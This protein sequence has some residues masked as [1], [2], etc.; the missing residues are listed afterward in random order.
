MSFSFKPKS[1]S[2]ADTMLGRMLGLL[3]DA[4]IKHRKF[5]LWP[6][7][8]L[9]GLCVF[10]TVHKLEFD[11]DRDNLVGS[12][13]KY[14]QLYLQ[15]KHEFP[16]Q[17]DM[18]VVVES[19]NTEKNRQFVERLGKKLD[20]ETGLF[21]NVFYKGDMKMLGRKALLFVPDS[22]LK[23]MNDALTNFLPFIKEFTRA[24]NL[25]SLFQ[26]VNTQIYHAKREANAD[27]DALLGAIPMLTRIVSQAGACLDRPGTPPSPGVTALFG[28][29][30]EAEQKIY[31][32]FTNGTSHIYLVTAQAA[33]DEKSGEAVDRMRKLVAETAEEVPGINI[34]VTGESVLEHDEMEQSQKDSTLASIVSL[35]ICALIFIYGYQETGRPLK[36]TLCLLVGLGYTMAFTTLVIGHLNILTI[37]FAPI[38]IGLAIDFGVHL[39]TRYE[40]ELRLGKSEEDAMRKAIVFTGQGILT[41]A[42]TT[43]VAFLA[44]GLTNFKGIQEMGIICGGGMIICFIPM[45]TLLPVLLFKGRQNVI[46]HSPGAV[47]E[48][49]R[50][51]AKIEGIWLD[52]PISTLIIT[53]ALTILAVT[54]FHRV[55]FD[56]NLLNMQSAGLSAVVFEKK[57]LDTKQQVLYGA[58][59]ADSAEQAV[60]LEAK[61]KLLPSVIDTVSMAPYLVADVSD[62]LKIIGQIKDEISSVNFLPTDT[63]PANL[64]DLSRTLYSTQGY[65]GAAADEVQKEAA[66]HPAPVENVQKPQTVP[67]EGAN[68]IAATDTNLAPQL[69]ALRDA[70]NQFRKKMLNMDQN[71][72][73][74][75]IAAFQQALLDDVRDTFQSLKE[76]D[77]S[78]RLKVEDLP[79]SLKN[80]FVG[81]H[82]KLMIQVS[83]RYDIW[84]HENQKQFVQQVRSVCPN[85]TGT[86]V[87]LLEYT[88]L[89]KN[90]YIEAA[91]YA[92]AVIVLMVL[93][94]FRSI[95]YLVLALLPVAIGAV[96]M[97]GLMGAFGIPFNPANIMTL[98][99]VIGIGITN[100]IHI[101]NRYAE[102]HNA[103]I[104]SKSTGKAVFVSGL[105]TF[106]GFA[107][108]IL[109]KHQGIRSLGE[110][111]A[112]GVALCMIAALTFLPAILK[113]WDSKKQP[114][115]GNAQ[116]SPGREEPRQKPQ[117]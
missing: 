79:S 28:A 29:G 116:S 94:H 41:G 9:F 23:D 72:A 19:E 103:S 90:S 82:G 31:I 71:V 89:L 14:H 76:Q 67:A 3:A 45:M 114:G 80:R 32:T 84:D 55:Y 37:T 111:M 46:D 61:L 70:I 47:R 18:V 115:G 38:L 26:L 64:E 50:L 104:L 57:L 59:V 39:I 34:G 5:F 102:E 106:S 48:D 62:K 110:V 117:G 87:Q 85:V 1:D 100:G 105:T 33:S 25:V 78:S 69:L 20:A 30:D 35:V 10:Y 16:A 113:L 66:S 99:L 13:K 12:D 15:Y 27:N 24:T 98:P 92:L 74:E 91:K 8:V 56:Y 109:A 93:L 51:R 21:T 60:E 42:L 81:I 7:F 75:K 11:V 53:A 58:V 2:L 52:R 95:I 112:L 17:D 88:E 6:Q 44:M 43:A 96:W 4:V 107:S 73:S 49:S 40:E 86:P 63:N 83:P 77:N 54:E 36:A 65:M 22:D 101:L 97:G 68:A 108:L